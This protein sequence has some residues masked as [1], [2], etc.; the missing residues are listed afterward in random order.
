M[1]LTVEPRRISIRGTRPAPE[2]TDAEGRAVQM[3]AFEIDYGP[4]ERIVELPM[5][6]DIDQA[7]AEQ[8]N[9]FLWIELPFQK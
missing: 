3:I 2:P 1:D 5:A 7:K 8:R 6:V 4:F 9:G